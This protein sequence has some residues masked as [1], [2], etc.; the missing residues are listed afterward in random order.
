MALYLPDYNAL[1]VHCPKT[2]GS[3]VVQTLKDKLELN[4]RQVGYKHSHKDLVGPIR[5]RKKPYTFTLVR[6]P[7]T[8]YGSYWQ[9]KMRAPVDGKH[10][11]NWQPGTLWHPN[12]EIDP[13]YGD[14]DFARFIE[15][16]TTR[17]NYLHDMYRL[18]TGLGT[19][20]TV[21]QIGKQET[22]TEDLIT[23]LD[24]IGAD[25]DKDLLLAAQP[26]NKAFGEKKAQ[27]TPELEAL[28]LE[29]EQR[30]LLDYGYD[31]KGLKSGPDAEPAPRSAGDRIV[32]SRPAKK[33]KK[34]PAN[35]N[36]VVP[37]PSLAQRVY[38]TVL[39]ESTRK[40]FYRWRHRTG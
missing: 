32:I 21:D 8:W 9:M 31:V 17:T 20:D 34:R 2:G 16:V 38:R 14:D 10:W 24:T 3:F 18:Y 15:K 23:F 40:S 11:Y 30:T 1:F 7:V 27:W 28:V 33:T 39:P 37:P 22:L 12:W 25:Y 19:Y 4:V 6:H 26:I 5:H 13:R 35:Q 29:A 36:K